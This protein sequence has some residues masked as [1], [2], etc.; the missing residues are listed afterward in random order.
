[1]NIQDII[2]RIKKEEVL[3]ERTVKKI[4]TKIQEIL[5]T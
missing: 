4:C 1:M 3:D 2:E 5:L